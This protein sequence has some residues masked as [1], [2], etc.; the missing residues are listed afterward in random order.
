MRAWRSGEDASIAGLALVDM[1]V[2]RPGP[3]ELLVR[4]EAAALNYSDLLMIG[5]RYQIRPERPFTPGQEIAGT[6]VETGSRIAAKVLWGGFAEYAL[7]RADMAMPIPDAI[8]SSAAAALPVVYTTAVVALTETANVQPG[9]WVL[10]FAATGGVGIASI[11]VARH[12]GA[13][14][15][16]VTSG[17]AKAEIAR[18]EGAEA[19]VDS[20][21]ADLP[22]AVMAATGG[23]GAQIVVDSVG[24]SATEAALKCL[25]WRGEILLVGFLSGEI[26]RIP[27]H[28]L[29]LQGAAAKGVYW[30]HDRDAAM[31]ARCSARVFELC[32]Q[33]VLRPR[34]SD[35][36]GLDDLPRALDDLQA[37]RSV[38]KLV[39]TLPGNG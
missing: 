22:G 37:R 34:V 26:P 20:A 3:G 23:E 16:A 21:D 39:L 33:G 7:V 4:V 19:V 17:E 18:A 31:V 15:I 12:L 29:L 9:D 1:P 8:T 28:R 35:G 13:R 10:I 6:V 32:A 24:G 27:A 2:P 38:G 11:Q 30:D 5:G 14:V 25:A 36:Y